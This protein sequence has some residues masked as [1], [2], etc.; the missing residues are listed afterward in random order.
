MSYLQFDFWLTNVDMI[1]QI[2]NMPRFSRRFLFQ[3]HIIL[4]LLKK[5]KNILLV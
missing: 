4:S 3:K 2:V 5:N 1:K